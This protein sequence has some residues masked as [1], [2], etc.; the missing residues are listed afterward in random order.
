MPIAPATATV[1]PIAAI[2]SVLVFNAFLAVFCIVLLVNLLF[3]LTVFCIGFSGIGFLI[4]G[5]GFLISGL[6]FSGIFGSVFLIS[7]LGFCD[8]G[9]SGL[10]FC[11]LGFSGLG[12]IS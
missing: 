7:G 12:L 1:A 3:C 9:F 11:G 2:P 6:G 5:V 4:S 10:G 8:S